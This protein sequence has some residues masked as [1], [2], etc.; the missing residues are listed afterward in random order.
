MEKA[1]YLLAGLILAHCALSSC[2]GSSDK[3]DT[4]TD[5][6]AT[7][8]PSRIPEV[9]TVV[10]EPKVFS[11]E[12][13]SNGKVSAHESADLNFAGSDAII[14]KIYVKNG[15]F[16]RKGQPI[17]SLDRFKLENQLSQN[18]NDLEKAR[19]EL[20]DVLI[21]QGYDP[22][23]PQS[24]PADVMKLARLR[25]GLDQAE[26]VLANT[27]RDLEQATLVAP[28]DG[29]VANLFQKANN[30]P[31]SSEPLCRIISS[32]RMDV[33]FPV[34]ESELPI[35]KTGDEVSVGAFASTDTYPGRVT[36]INPLVDKDGLVKVRAEVSGAKNLFDGMNVKVSLFRAIDKQLVVPKSAVVLRSGK[37]VIFTLSGDKAM[38]NYV[39]TGLENMNECVVL[40]GLE[41]GMEVIYDGNVNLAHEAP[42]KV[43]AAGN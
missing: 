40:D 35:I 30:R 37:Q 24:V 36:E 15:D 43:V 8:L 4:D 3:S 41:P 32:G 38:W 42:V 20:A 39:H 21:G 25:S 1:S 14:S 16:V 10:L 11:H 7:V 6:V 12:I 23:K 13:V 28:F 27:T 9:K 34:L 33:E 31:N 22:D 19:L 2:S 29:V 18:K 17:A 26:T 5:S